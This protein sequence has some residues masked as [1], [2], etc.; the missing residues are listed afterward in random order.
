MPAARDFLVHGLLAGLLAGL[1]AFG[2]AYAVGEPSLNAAITL[3]DSAT[4]HT[5]TE[6]SF[7]TQDEGAA[8]DRTGAPTE[9][10][11]W[12]QSTLG[13]LTGTVVAGATLGGLLGMLSALALGRLGAL[14]PRASTL[15][16]AGLGFVGG[17][18]VPFL[19]YPPNP[20]GVGDPGTIG[21]RTAA[22]FSLLAISLIALVTAVLVGRRL[23][24]R[25]GGWYAFLAAALGYLV[26]C[27]GAVAAMPRFAEIPDGY[28]AGLLYDF[29][30]ASLATA[31]TLWAVLGV[32]LAEAVHR[33]TTRAATPA[34][35]FTG[36]AS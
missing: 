24:V 19:G 9:V 13:L 35:A 31:L 23:A 2:A 34:P 21:V 17:Y 32:A 20:P 14:T 26:V 18:L 16:V 6:P 33:L 5:A 10:A 12:L 29:R 30:L 3:E 15:A 4:G 7:G 11:R 25:I 8:H 1:F 28:P 22:F 36:A 27:T